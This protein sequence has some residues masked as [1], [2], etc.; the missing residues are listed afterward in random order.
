MIDPLWRTFGPPDYALYDQGAE[1]TGGDFGR[2]ASLS[3]CW[4]PAR[5]HPGRMGCASAG[6]TCSRRSTTRAVKW[7]SH[8]TLTRLRPRSSSQHGPGLCRRR[9]IVLVHPSVN[10]FWVERRGLPWT[11]WVKTGATRTKP[12]ARRASEL[13][14]AA[15]KALVELDCKRDCNEP[16]EVDRD[17]KWRSTPAHR[18]PASSGVATRVT[19][20]IGQGWA[21]LCNS[22]ARPHRAWATHRAELG[23]CRSSQVSQVFPMGAIECQRLE[24]IPRDLLMAKERLRFDSGKLG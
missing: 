10:A 16:N 11:W 24:A 19:W 14:D 18:R 22:A 7:F 2:N 23:K 17:E 5:A 20:S 9:G 21:M 1:L 13:R 15:R 3:S 4:L 6:A 8:E 12:E